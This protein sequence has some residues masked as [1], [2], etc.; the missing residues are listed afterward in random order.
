MAPPFTL[1]LSASRPSSRCGERL[2]AC[3]S[4]TSARDVDHRQ[5]GAF[6]QQADR[7]RR[8]TLPMISG[9]A[10]RPPPRD[11]RFAADFARPHSRGP[12]LEA[13]Q[14]RHRIGQRRAVARSVTPSLNPGAAWPAP[15]A[16]R[17][18]A[19]RAR[20]AALSCRRGGC[21]RLVAVQLEDF[22]AP[23]ARSRRRRSPPPAP[24]PRARKDCEAGIRLARDAAV[25]F[26]RFSAVWIIGNAGAGIGERLPT[27]SP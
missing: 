26:A 17:G 20:P 5:T 2:R 6:E 8:P 18:G 11:A 4:L 10:R 9:G 14:R 23:P 24:P 1:S 15:R 19:C 7:R 12:A 3:A 22:M 13:H 25:F 21:L 27:C 16:A